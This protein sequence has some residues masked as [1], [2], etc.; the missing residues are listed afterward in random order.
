MGRRIGKKVYCSPYFT[1]LQG[2]KLIPYLRMETLKNHTLSPIAK[3]VSRNIL[4]GEER[5]ETFVFADYTICSNE[6]KTNTAK[7]PVVNLAMVI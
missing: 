4:S 6:K 2:Q 1:A 3:D 5:V 7:S